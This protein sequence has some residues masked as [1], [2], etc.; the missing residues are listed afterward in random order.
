MTNIYLV[1]TSR[2]TW[3]KG[4]DAFVAIYNAC[5]GYEDIKQAQIYCFKFPPEKKWWEALLEV[6][7]DEMGAVTFPKGVEYVDLG[8]MQ[9]N[10]IASKIC[11][12]ANRIENHLAS[13][14]AH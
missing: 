4:P 7:V 10:G 6:N 12:I 11:T 2:Q 9:M 3:G 13:R 14:K 5:Q 1:M 8:V